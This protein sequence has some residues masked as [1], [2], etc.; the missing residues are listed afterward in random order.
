MATEE[1]GRR[2]KG[3]YHDAFK[4]ANNTHR[5]CRR[6]STEKRLGFR[7]SPN[8]G[9]SHNNMTWL[10]QSRIW[11]SHR[12]VTHLLDQSSPQA[13]TWGSTEA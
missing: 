1:E 3:I 10:H 7:Q 13:G 12:R 9:T 2:R 11:S 4:E 6:A 5:R 8:S